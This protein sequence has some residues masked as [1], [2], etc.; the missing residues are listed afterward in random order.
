MLPGF[1]GNFILTPSQLV[2]ALPDIQAVC[3]FPPGERDQVLARI[4]DA[5]ADSAPR[6]PEDVLDVL[7]R[8]G[9]WAAG[10]SMGLVSI[11][12]PTA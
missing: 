11:C 6:S 3:G 4:D 8:R 5:L 7:P 9:R 1:L 2:A 10:R 12:Q